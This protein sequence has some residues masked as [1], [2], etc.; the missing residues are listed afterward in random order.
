MSV[1][2]TSLHTQLFHVRPGVVEVKP[3]RPVASNEEKRETGEEGVRQEAAKFQS[4][5]PAFPVQC[6]AARCGNGIP[7]ILLPTMHHCRRLDIASQGGFWP[8]I[9]ETW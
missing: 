8:L 2:L 9:K 5:T 7:T 4:K 6:M 3:K 1:S